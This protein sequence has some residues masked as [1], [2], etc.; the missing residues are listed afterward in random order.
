MRKLIMFLFSLILL[1]S[2]GCKS[3]DRSYSINIRH[4]AG[5]AGLTRIYEINERGIVV[6]TNCDFENCK[7]MVLYK[8]EFR[9]SQ[10]DS[11]LNIVSSLHLDTLKNNYSTDMDDGL[12][13]EIKLNI[14]VS[15]KKIGLSNYKLP[16]ID[17]LFRLIDN[18]IP[19]SKYRFYSWGD[20]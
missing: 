2:G 7:E 9:K 15:D 6:K 3:N 1:I 13:S 10:A 11:I 17:S 5:A 20:E 4:F 8:C 16:S 18:Q 12:Y 19:I 14:G